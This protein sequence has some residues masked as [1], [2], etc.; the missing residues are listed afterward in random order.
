MYHI[1]LIN[2]FFAFSLQSIDHRKCKLFLVRKNCTLPPG[3][4]PIVLQN[5]E[6]LLKFH[7]TYYNTL[8]FFN[9]YCNTFDILQYLLQYFRDFTIHI[10]IFLSFCRTYCNT[11]ETLQYFECIAILFAMILKCCNTY[12]NTLIF[13][14]THYVTLII[15]IFVL[16]FNSL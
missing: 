6:I 14:D 15:L 9:K 12:C 13:C 5:I 7:N 10:A 8:R 1:Y 2:Y 3:M 11:F 16:I 4:V